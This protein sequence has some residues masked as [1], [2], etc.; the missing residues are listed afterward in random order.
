MWYETLQTKE[1]LLADLESAVID[2]GSK[3]KKEKE[4]RKVRI[5]HLRGS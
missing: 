4:E 5:G 2:T 1:R 3:I